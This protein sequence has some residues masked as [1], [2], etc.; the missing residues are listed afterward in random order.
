M[1][2]RARVLTCEVAGAPQ[3][4]DDARP[5]R[6]ARGRE[7]DH[8]GHASTCSLFAGGDGT[9]RDLSGSAAAV[10]ARHRRS[11]WRENALRCVHGDAA[12]AAALIA[13]LLDGGLV[14]ADTAE[15]RDIDE[16]ALREGRVATR[17]YGELPVP[18]IGGFLQ[19]AKYEWTRSGRTRARRDRRVRRRPRRRPSWRAGAGTGHTLAAIKHASAS[20][21][22]CWDS[23]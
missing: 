17:Y 2:W 18:R 5:I 4:A 12:D 22:R 23:M 14:A 11:G 10:A 16:D 9:A 8:G 7:G 19:H 1:R 20:T 13:R 6:H 15:V 3:S 21:G